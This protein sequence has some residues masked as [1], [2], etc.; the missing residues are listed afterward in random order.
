MF[1]DFG[2]ENR[3]GL[4][5]YNSENVQNQIYS[6]FS[7]EIWMIFALHYI[8]YN[9]P[10]PRKRKGNKPRERER[11]KEREIEREREKEK[12]ID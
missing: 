4:K 2:K 3:G 11:E 8:S 5:A 7:D 9:A 6:G 12:E 1:S 10:E